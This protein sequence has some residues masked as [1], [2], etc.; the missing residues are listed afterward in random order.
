[1]AL[2]DF[3][4]KQFLLER[5]E[6]VGLY[7]AGGLAFLLI[8]LTLFWPGAAIFHSSPKPEAKTIV[9]ESRKKND[10]IRTAAPQGQAEIDTLRKVDSQLLKQAAT[11]S[12]DPAGFRLGSEMFAP[13]DVR[14][15]KRRNPTIVAPDEFMA[16]IEPA[17]ISN[18][19][20]VYERDGTVRVAILKTTKKSEKSGDK[21]RDPW[22][23]WDNFYQGGNRGGGGGPSGPGM[24][25]GGGPSGPGMGGGGSGGPMGGGSGGGGRGG[26]GPGAGG[27]GGMFGDDKKNQEIQYITKEEADKLQSLEYA[28]DL[29]PKPMAIVAG[30]FPLKAQVDEFQ[31]ALKIDSPYKVVFE[32]TVTEKTKKGDDVKAAFRF[33][34]F[35]IQ[36]RDLAPDGKPAGEW[37]KLDLE[38]KDSPYLQLVVLVNKEFADEDAKLQP[39]LWPGLIMR[40]PIQV[41]L[42]KDKNATA[43]HHK[44]YPEFEEKLPKIEKTL[45]SLTPKQAAPTGNSKFGD[46]STFN[47]FGGP[48][49]APTDSNDNTPAASQEWTPTEFCVLRFLDVTIQPGHSY[50]YQIQV[51][52]ANPN[53]NKPDTEVA[54]HDLTVP[55]ELQSAWYPVKG[56]DGNV[57]R[58]SVPTDVHYYAVDEQQLHKRGE[59]KGVNAGLAHDSQRQAV[60]QIHRWL[61]RYELPRGSVTSS[62]PV[63]DW[64]IGERLFVFRGES[65]SQR[66]PM[67]VPIWAPEQSSFILAGQAGRGRDRKPIS[68]V[69]LMDAAKAPMLVDFEGGNLSY[70]HRAAPLPKTEDGTP[71]EGAKATSAG[72]ARSAAS[73]MELLFLTPDGRLEARNSGR[74]EDDAERKDREKQYTE[75]IEEASGKPQEQP[76]KPMP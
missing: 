41:P 68:Q 36:R 51:R 16:R 69:H 13:R 47:P 8:F 4:Y 29:F 12:E 5:G 76:Q 31:K 32:Q 75:R 15:S 43:D 23:Q 42:P 38:T 74:D 2:K 45:A 14:S 63:G 22:K 11:V 72:D 40:R 55:K 54:Y 7:I 49:A 19:M 6:R 61:D 65:L 64:V 1:M 26:F 52:M 59:Y 62:Y 50:E 66:A 34:G 60:V 33:T 39:L 73:A 37:Q 9:E 46:T 18:Y 48:D 28:R 35:N 57:L 20:F 30:S 3:D 27:G 70:H 71:Q 56:A 25:G 44:P 17:Q 53:Y 58:V 67:H 10:L 21:K 24:G